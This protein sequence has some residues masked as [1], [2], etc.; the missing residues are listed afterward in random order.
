MRYEIPAAKQMLAIVM[1]GLIAAPVAAQDLNTLDRHLQ[2]QQWQRV[3]EHQN[4][5]RAPDPK[6]KPRARASRVS[7]CSP[8][9][10]PAAEKRALN[11]EYARRAKSDGKARADAWVR[12]EGIR[13]HQR[14]VADGVCPG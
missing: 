12:V 2:H 11:A 10:M 3:Q 9:A 14:L 5:M 8:D 13:F 4:R 6:K 1:A 7:S